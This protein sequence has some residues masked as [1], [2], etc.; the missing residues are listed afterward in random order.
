[1]ANCNQCKSQFE[2]TDDDR[3]FYNRIGPVIHGVKYTISEPTLCPDCRQRRRLSFRNES[4]LYKR[5]C[6]KTG[7]EIISMYSPDKPYKIYD[8]KEWWGDGWNPLEYGKNFDFSKPFFQQFYELQL[9]VPRVSLTNTNSENSEY[10]NYTANNRNCYF[11]FSNSYGHN[12]SCLYGTCIARSRSCMDNIFIE[13]SEMC[14]DCC[15]SKKCY[16]LFSSVDCENCSDSWFLSDCK[17]C[18][19]CFGCKGLRNKTYCI[20]N[21]PVSEEEYAKF[22]T[23]NNLGDY[24]ICKAM[25][26]KAYGFFLTLPNVFSRQ[27]NCQSC[28]GDYLIN[29]KKCYEGFDVS[30]SEDCKFVQYSVNGNKDVYDASHSGGSEVSYECMSLVSGKSCIGCNIIW[31]D[32]SDLAYCDLC[33]NNSSNLFGCI[34]LRHKKYCVLNKQYSEEEYYKL[35]PRIIEHMRKTGEW[36]EFFPGSISPFGYNETLADIYFP[37]KKKEAVSIGFKWSDYEPPAPKAAKIIPAS[38]LPNDTKDIPD[39]ILNW[40]IECEATKKPFILQKQELKFYREQNLPIPRRH[41]D[42]RYKDR[43]ALRNPRKLWSRTC[44]KCGTA[45]RTSYSP[46]RPEKVYCEECYLKEVY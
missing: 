25:K 18:K 2:I 37:L 35:V 4:R 16:K 28:T 12:E 39:D 21:K 9:K 19:N 31:W 45:I 29:S 23:D 3:R 46:D 43:M 27:S 34:G 32:I 26:A 10:T 1:M 22:I 5:N 20:F 42:V 15:S 11:I 14:Y 17:S 33:F 30:D 6:D 41:P 24:S 38:K 44:A 36:G 8:Q 7:K 40:A 13:D